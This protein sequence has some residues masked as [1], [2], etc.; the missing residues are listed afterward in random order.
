[1]GGN[2]GKSNYN[3]WSLRTNSTYNV[4]E[5]KDRSFLNKMRVGVNISYARSKSSGI[6][7]NSEYGSVLGSALAFDPTVPVY[8]TNPESVLAYNVGGLP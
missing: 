2:Y 7:T 1:M 6:E 3:R 5:T 8:A 4:F